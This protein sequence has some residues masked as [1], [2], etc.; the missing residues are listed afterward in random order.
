MKQIDVAIIGAGAAGMMCALEARKRG[1][2]VILLDHAAKIGE[3][4]RI[5]GGGRC[6][7]TN[8]D[9]RASRFLSQNP[10]F[11][12]SALKRFTPADFIEM[13]EHHKI[14]WFEKKDKNASGALFCQQSASQI[15][16]MFLSELFALDVHPQME[17]PVSDIA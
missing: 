16:D 4:I 5:S 7:F 6:N 14:E 2:S 9:A 3:K 10:H 15:I 17:S 8:I 11:C 12:K 1:R 13:I